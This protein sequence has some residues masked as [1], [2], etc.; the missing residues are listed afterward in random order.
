MTT[1]KLRWKGGLEIKPINAAG[2]R[3]NY[4]VKDGLEMKPKEKDKCGGAAEK[5]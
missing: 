5:R 1:G 4:G 3:R 2:R